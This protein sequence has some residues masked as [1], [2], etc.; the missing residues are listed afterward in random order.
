MTVNELIEALAEFDGE[1][2]VTVYVPEQGEYYPIDTPKVV[3]TFLP[4]YW[5]L[6]DE[7]TGKL[8][9]HSFRPH[10]DAEWAKDKPTTHV[11]SLY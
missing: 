2:E 4:E 11:V 9:C 5:G 3:K 6:M 8:E 10:T 1:V 7:S